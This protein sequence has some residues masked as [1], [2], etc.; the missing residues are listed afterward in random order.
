MC[1]WV[2]T[3]GTEQP[4]SLTKYLRDGVEIGTALINCVHYKDL[5]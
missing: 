3:E 4:L 1:I 2:L 5:T